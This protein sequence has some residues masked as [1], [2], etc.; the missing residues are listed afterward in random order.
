MLP[1]AT[2][3]ATWHSALL[4][5]AASVSKSAAASASSWPPASVSTPMTHSTSPSASATGAMAS[6]P[7]R[8]TAQNLT[9]LLATACGSS[10]HFVPLARKLSMA[11]KETPSPSPRGTG[12]PS[13]APSAAAGRASVLPRMRLASALD[14]AATYL[15]AFGTN[16][17]GASTSSASVGASSA[18]GEA[19]SPMAGSVG[20]DSSSGSGIFTSLSGRPRTP[21]P[22]N[23]PADGAKGG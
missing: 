8:G 18:S 19:S 15:R 3:I 9:D 10:R 22:R 5:L 23:S 1:F 11:S 20:G 12:A 7:M 13:S 21:A 4:A 16:L 2:S 6:E 14:A 17:G